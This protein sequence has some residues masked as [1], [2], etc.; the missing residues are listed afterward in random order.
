MDKIVI[1]VPKGTDVN[2]KYVDSYIEEEM[3]NERF[4]K[5]FGKDAIETNLKKD[6]T[7]SQKQIN[8]IFGDSGGYYITEQ[9]LLKWASYGTRGEVLYKRR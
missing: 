4:T 3:T 6:E 1:E 2:I 5:M 7:Y 9:R 8:N